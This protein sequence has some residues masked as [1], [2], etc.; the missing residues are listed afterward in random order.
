[1]S[2]DL[3]FITNQPGST[4]LERFKDLIKS[5]TQYFDCLVGFFYTSGFYKLYDSLEQVERIR[6]LI[7]INTDRKSL[8]LI[9]SSHNQETL[10]LS[11]RETKEEFKNEIL[12]E[13]EESDDK[14]TVE[15]G[16]L[17]FIEWLNNSKSDDPSKKPKLQIK[18]YPFSK[19]H[20]KLYIMTFA[21]GDRDRG[22]IITG[23]SNFT[24]AGLVDNLEL[25]VELKNTSDYN[26]AI[27]LFNEL[28]NKSVDVSQEYIDTIQTSTWLNKNITPYQ[29]YLKFLYE[30]L[31]EK[32]NLDQEQISTT[33]LPKDFIEL[34]YQR[35]AVID[36]KNKL[37]EY[38]GVFLSD[39][40]GLGKT[41]ISAMLAQQLDGRHLIICPP[42]LK[43]YWE[44]TFRDFNVPAT[45]VSLG[46]LD[47][48]IN[49][50]RKTEYKNVFIDEAH[51]FRNELTPTYAKLKEICWGKR[52]ILV[53]ATPQ[54]NTPND[55]LSLIKLF[56]KGRNSNIP[57]LKNLEIYFDTL[58]KR[59]KEVNRS[60]DYNTYVNI[61]KD[62]A[63]R[64]RENVLKYL[65]VRRTRK[66]IKE[67]FINDLT[68]KGLKFPEIETPQKL[69]YQFDNEIESIFNETISK[70]KQFKYARYIPILYLKHFDPEEKIG[71]LNMRKFMK[72]LLVK[73]LDSSFYAFK[74]TLERFISSYEKF[75]KMF[76]QGIIYLSKKY[77]DKMFDL[78]DNDNIEGIMNLVEEEKI[79]AYKVDEFNK[80]FLT[81][82]NNDLKILNEIKKLWQDVTTDPKIEAF[83][84]TL[85]KDPVLKENQIIV[86]TESKETAEYLEEN[87]KSIY[88]DAV[89]SYSSKS[90]ALI[91]Q[92]IIDNFDPKSNNPKNDIKILISTDILSEGVNLHRANVVI[93]YDIPWNP[94]R[95]IQRVGRINRVDTNFD[96]IFIYNFFPTIQS[97]EEIKLEEAAISKLE[98]FH[99]ILGED[100]AYLTEGE[101]ITSFELF[102]RLNSKEILEGEEDED[103]ELKYLY[104]IRKIRDNDK[105]LYEKIKHLPKKAR[106]AKSYAVDKESLLTF[107]RKGKIRKIFISNEES[108]KEL[109]FFQAAEMLKADQNTKREKIETKYYG[110]LD[111]NKNAFKSSIIKDVQEGRLR[112]GRSSEV[113]LKHI[114]KALLKL[115]GFTED[116][117]DYLKKVHNLLEEGVL[118]KF[119]T[120]CIINEIGKEKNHLK[121]YDIIK[122]NI[123]DIYFEKS[124]IE[125]SIQASGPREIILS[126]YLIKKE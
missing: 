102:N 50:I 94:I 10:V 53:S 91:K 29:L 7:G 86:F 3:T 69:Y 77:N 14:I 106:S 90:S 23:S 52:I 109:D 113:K 99:D 56:Q 12:K 54:H 42:I 97:N 110:F 89:L 116:N 59:L 126:E 124:L 78:L 24:Q 98:A 107:F 11:H 63:K 18:A 13:M 81:D 61:V 115:D 43:D 58:E 49:L 76:D 39:V 103:S 38:G 72:V 100:A 26:F 51:R 47:E 80:A 33:F 93:N 68:K 122:R 30:Y 64:I 55:I 123:S 125:S 35:E 15:E 65:I 46:T 96:K 120:K 79:R 73:R 112:G 57:N 20:A 19:I 92:K 28:W 9:E 8:E 75:I 1:M 16:V 45:V 71:Q 111:N 62:N 104:E 31:K 25:N 83:K 41:Y 101:E 2:T 88:N 105:D 36:A 21:E 60:T 48:A 119:I 4:L 44:S 66:D 118:P 74:L 40:V 121:I 82:L 5:N 70:I 22:R 84:L 27:D 37:D 6:I 85:S 17:K 108:T 114:I 32:I 67:Y 34:E 87:L 117:K 95:I